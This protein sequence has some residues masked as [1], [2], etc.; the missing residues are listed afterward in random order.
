MGMSAAADSRKSIQYWRGVPVQLLP[1]SGDV[2]HH[3]ITAIDFFTALP[4]A[5]PTSFTRTLMILPSSPPPFCLH[6]EGRCASLFS[7]GEGSLS[8]NTIKFVLLRSTS[9]FL[10]VLAFL[11][12]N[13]TNYPNRLLATLGNIICYSGAGTVRYYNNIL[14]LSYRQT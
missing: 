7:S 11:R 13:S 14:I 3:K 6:Q 4:G 8:R 12:R 9:L 1:S 5:F 2:Y 10:L